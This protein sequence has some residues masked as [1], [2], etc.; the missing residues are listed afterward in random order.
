M[1]FKSKLKAIGKGLVEIV[2]KIAMPGLGGSR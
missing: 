2:V 1:S